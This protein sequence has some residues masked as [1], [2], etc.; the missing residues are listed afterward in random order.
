M[1]S[2]AARLMPQK[3]PENPTQVAVQSV[4]KQLDLA[5]KLLHAASPDH[6]EKG[7]RSKMIEIA[8]EAYEHSV[9]ALGKLPPLPPE[10]LRKIFDLMKQ[11]RTRLAEVDF[12]RAPK[13]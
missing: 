3:L 7:R 1:E 11:F 13:I 5:L 12:D 9:E 2:T 8:R 4:L 6:K 10:T